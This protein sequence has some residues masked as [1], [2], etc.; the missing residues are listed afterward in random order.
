MNMHQT[1][2]NNRR[3]SNIGRLPPVD[4]KPTCPQ[5]DDLIKY[6]FESWNKVTQDIERNSGNTMIYHEEHQC[7]RDFEPFD[8]E[9]Y[10]GRRLVQTNMQNAQNS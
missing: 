3:P 10:W 4:N 9:R 7:L 5:H 8:L 6:I 1:N 2:G